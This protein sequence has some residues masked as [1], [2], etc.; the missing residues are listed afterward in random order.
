M[1]D[2]NGPVDR[3]LDE[4]FDRLAG[5]GHAGRRALAEAEDHLRAAATDAAAHGVP[6]AQAEADAVARFG[7]PARIAAQLR[8]IHGRTTL[9]AGVSAVM[10]AGGLALLALGATYLITAVEMAVL[11]RMQPEWEPYCPSYV[12]QGFSQ[13]CSMS[14]PAMHDNGWA[15]TLAGLLGT[16]ALLARWQAVRRGWLPP[17]PR[18]FPLL[19]AGL[20]AVAAVALF[21]LPTTPADPGILSAGGRL[22]V[23][24]GPG[25]RPTIIASG[26]ALLASIAAGLWHLVRLRHVRPG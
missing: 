22:R 19:C 13:G 21:V 6:P 26:V 1:T 25:L 7:P 11:L 10:L 12:S 17:A 18:R 20:F 5:T 24:Y 4:L 14:V 15:A 8:G 23:E 2:V 9:D 3:Y 16:L